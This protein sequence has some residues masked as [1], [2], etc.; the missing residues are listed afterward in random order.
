M[1]SEHDYI[2]YLLL[3]QKDAS[4]RLSQV[5]YEWKITESYERSPGCERSSN[6]IV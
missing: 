1:S 6:T 4:S 2:I 3:T 5:K